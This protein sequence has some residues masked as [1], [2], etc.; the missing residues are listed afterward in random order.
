MGG[1]ATSSGINYQASVVAY[2]YVHILTG[3]KLRWLQVRDDTPTAI[4][5][6]TKGPGDDARIEFATPVRPVEVQAKRG[7]TR[8]PRLTEVFARVRDAHDT[9]SEVVLV[10]DSKASGPVR[11]DLGHQLARLRAGRTDELREPAKSLLESLG[12]DS[13]KVLCRVRVTVLDPDWEPAGADAKRVVE[14]LADNLEDQDQAEAAWHVLVADGVRVCADRSRR[15]RCDL[16]DLLERAGIKMLPPRETRKWHDDL[17]HSKRLLDADEP[18]AA[19]AL[20]RQIDAELPSGNPDSAILYRLN[21]HK[22]SA[23]LGLRRSNDAIRFAQRALDHDANGIYALAN[24]ATAYA[25]DGQPKR[26]QE[27]AERMLGLHGDATDA[28]S[29]RVQV[30]ALV[31]QPIPEVPAVVKEAAA[32]RKNWVRV[33]LQLGRASEAQEVSARLLAAGDRSPETLGLRVQSLLH[34]I[35]QLDPGDRR[36]RAEEIERLCSET[37]DG[38]TR[39]VATEL[40]QALRGRSAARRILGRPKDARTD[41]DR[42]LLVRPDDPEILLEAAQARAFS[43]DSTEALSVPARRARPRGAGVDPALPERQ[44]PRL[45][46]PGPPLCPLGRVLRLPPRRRPGRGARSG[47]GGLRPRL[48]RDAAVS[49]WVP[50][51]AVVS[52]DS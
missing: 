4:S 48:P 51:S 14:L 49:P 21:Q 34:D 16:V 1:D 17:R 52:D 12:A 44:P 9:V 35:D 45:R 37:V 36:V 2:V 25:L 31:G 41:A 27:M 28:W 13:L 43:Q 39:L 32:F 29:V 15:N 20:L 18:A 24:L 23:S 30:S 3:S 8:G 7:L 26:A 46:A 40:A 47:A 19:L 33:C 42:A 11:I 50:L 6:E 22:A 10:V 38:S 5:G